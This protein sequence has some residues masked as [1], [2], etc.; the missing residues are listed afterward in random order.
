[1]HPGLKSSRCSIRQTGCHTEKV[2]MKNSKQGL[3]LHKNW[4]SQATDCLKKNHENR[5]EKFRSTSSKLTL[6]VLSP[7]M[8]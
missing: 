3:K 4:L 2:L 1:M 6:D 8:I 7:N 5:L